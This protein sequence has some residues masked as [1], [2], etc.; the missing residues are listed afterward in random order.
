MTSSKDYSIDLNAR[1][2]SGRTALRLAC[3]NHRTE[4]VEVIVKNWKE[5][6]I[7]I[8]AQDNQGRTQLEIVRWRIGIS[9][10]DK[11][12]NRIKEI[13]EDEYSKMDVTDLDKTDNWLLWDKNGQNRTRLTLQYV[14]MYKIG[15]YEQ[16]TKKKIKVI[17]M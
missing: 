11:N 4:A 2:D 8:K 1:D 17:C 10:N 7:D 3:K 6:G 9:P 16:M 15:Q 12:L 13:L 5:F 14:C